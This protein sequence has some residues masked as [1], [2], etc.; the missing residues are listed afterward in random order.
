MAL[1]TTQ[2]VAPPY[3]DTGIAVVPGAHPLAK[4][5]I[6]QKAVHKTLRQVW[7]YK[8]QN[9]STKH[10]MAFATFTLHVKTSEDQRM[11][12]SRE[13]AFAGAMIRDRTKYS[14]RLRCARCY[15]TSMDGMGIVL[16]R[17]TATVRRVGSPRV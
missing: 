11:R 16:G 8:T 14:N 3:L 15:D 2:Q 13:N 9:G 12:G 4:N 5:P 10:K 17:E 1:S 7:M 6:R